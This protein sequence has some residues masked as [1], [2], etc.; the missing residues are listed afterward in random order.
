MSNYIKIFLFSIVVAIMLFMIRIQTISSIHFIHDTTWLLSQAYAYLSQLLELNR[1]TS[2]SLRI[3]SYWEAAKLLSNFVIKIIFVLWDTSKFHLFSANIL[4]NW[5]IK[6][7][8]LNAVILI[9]SENIIILMYG[10][11]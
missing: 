1:P 7:E 2:S 8:K 9:G 11:I 5:L 10:D 4:A 6:F 3:Q